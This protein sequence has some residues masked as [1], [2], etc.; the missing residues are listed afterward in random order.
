MEL[1]QRMDTWEHIFVS[2]ST[3]PSTEAENTPARPLA[4]PYRDVPIF[5]NSF[6]RVSCLRQLIEWLQSNEYCRI[7]VID[8]ASTYQPLLAYYGTI[9]TTGVTVIRLGE[10]VGS[11]AL[12]ERNVL[13]MVG[14]T[15]EFV[16]TDSDVV[17]AASCPGS[18]VQHL[19]GLL[20]A[21][22]YIV[23]YGPTLLACCVE[24][25]GLLNPIKS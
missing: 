1:K 3:P 18:V 20:N 21:Y 11:R 5:I 16:Y 2:Q 9:E 4:L 14:V 10:N 25:Q 19:Q 22:P 17:P 8:N 23:P 13:G 24:L 6:N 12:W 7:F 15:S